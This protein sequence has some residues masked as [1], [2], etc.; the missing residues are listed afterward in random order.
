MYRNLI[1]A[2]RPQARLLSQTRVP[3]NNLA[4]TSSLGLRFNS[5]N[6]TP[7]DKKP[8]D[9]RFPRGFGNFF[10]QG[11][12][13]KSSNNNDGKQNQEP[14]QEPEKPNE[15]DNKKKKKQTTE[16]QVITIATSP[17][18][19][20]MSLV[21]TYF[22]FKLMNP[23]ES[24][25][26]ELSFQEFRSNFLEK[27]LVKKVT[28][29]NKKTA[30]ATLHGGSDHHPGLTVY[31]NIGSVRAFEESMESIQQ[32][33]GIPTSERIPIIYK[34]RIGVVNLLLN[35]A[36][37]LFLLG[38]LVYL[39]RKA[40]SGAGKGG[41]FNIGKSK[42]KV[43]NQETN[44]K[45]N[46]KDVAGMEEAKEEIMEFVKFLKNPK[47]YEKLGAKIPKGAI[48]SGPPGTGKTL[49]AK[50]TA[51][52]A[53]VPFL[54]V[55]GSEFVEMFVGVGPSRVRDLFAMAKKQ[56]PCIIFVDEIDA[57]GKSRGRGGNFGGNDE[58]ESTLN[59]LLVEMDGFDTNEHVVVLAGTN[60]PDV[61]DSAL[62]RPG[63]FD[64]HIHID[65]PDIKG[66][67]DIFMVHLR[68]IVTK[69]DKK[70]LADKLAA[71][72]PGF[73]GA[74]IANVCN[75][76]ALI[77]ARYQN[78]SV[79]EKHF[80]Q[81]VDRVIAGLEK[82]SKVL[83]PEEKKTVAY[84]EAGHAV[85]GWFL[86]HADP[87]LKVSIIP[88]AKGTLGFAQFLP[89][90][91]YLFTVEQLFDRMCMT[92]GGR[93][94]EQ[95]FFGTITTGAHDDL[96]KVTKLAY[97]QIA[98]YGMNNKVGQVNFQQENEFQK[99]FS[100]DTSRL[101]D[102]EVRELIDRAYQKTTELLTH[103]KEA[104]E[105]VAQLLLEK[106]V[107]NR[108]DMINLLGKRPFPDKVQYEEYIL[109]NSEESEK[110]KEN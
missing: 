103:N 72:T 28:I 56:A 48:L 67:S 102:T 75:E 71:L 94:S 5:S 105:K 39:S 61:L 3:L 107:L 30:Y 90:D 12:T 99:P 60:R 14:E 7:Q 26:R 96:Q 86:Q 32:G 35:L 66:R 10:G 62:K 23:T 25:A 91:Q 41:I 97:A 110:P 50:A 98:Q 54:S 40:S 22:I 44:V 77:A 85:C 88:R 19:I 73:A 46:F 43:Y 81:A 69:A 21:L 76:A 42:A 70:K 92:L 64:R 101:I 16:E 33:L 100:E 53:G 24:D 87:L 4:R 51:G 95:I 13:K 47:Q 63:R 52:E 108:E 31:F 2:I 29:Y 38:G 49:L 57:I 18:S 37:T 8:Q 17:Q 78:D 84:H 11:E 74:D 58:R 55:S 1:T 83:S 6:N 15:N 80:I 59:Q 27:G 104:I 34:E 20:I 65:A 9:D 68:R 93:V 45:I 79:E 36:P 106:E 109:G 89:K 82:K